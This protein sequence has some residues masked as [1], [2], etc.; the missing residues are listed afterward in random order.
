MFDDINTEEISK[1][2][3]LK[4]AGAAAATTATAASA[5]AAAASE[6]AFADSTV[7]T[8][9]AQTEL[10]AHAGE[11]IGRLEADGVIGSAAFENAT[12]VSL[13]QATA[14]REG[15]AA[16]R[17]PSGVGASRWL[18]APRETT[19]TDVLLAVDRVHGTAYAT[20]TSRGRSD[21]TVYTG[22]DAATQSVDAAEVSTC[23]RVCTSTQCDYS[24]PIYLGYEYI[25]VE[26]KRPEVT[27]C[28]PIINCR[29]P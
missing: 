13:S 12:V 20:V 11:L 6:G 29:C 26:M 18:V 10:T 4:S 25:E 22:G 1:R 28:V 2:Q 3:L 5:G 21:V 9:T 27:I 7:S 14:D 8:E 17:S 23:G 16:I 24:F 15:V 19:E